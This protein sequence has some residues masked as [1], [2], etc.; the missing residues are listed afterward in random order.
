M[1]RVRVGV[2]VSVR[3]RVRVRVRARAANEGQNR[4]QMLLQTKEEIYE[5]FAK[6]KN[7]TKVSQG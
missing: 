3:V 7:Y 2:S 5:A 6:W 4:K 1:V